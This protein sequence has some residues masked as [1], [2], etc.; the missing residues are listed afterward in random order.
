MARYLVERTFPEG[1]QISV[2]HR[3]HPE[4]LHGDARRQGGTMR[5]FG[6]NA[7]RAQCVPDRTSSEGRQVKGL[8][9]SF[10]ERS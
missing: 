6:P 10:A 3:G 9:A 7:R 1:F 5:S 8:R 2:G 4:R